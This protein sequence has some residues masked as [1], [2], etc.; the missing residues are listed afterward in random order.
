VRTWKLD[1]RRR[2][3]LHRVPHAASATE[4]DVC[5][6]NDATA[7]ASSCCC[8]R[9]LATMVSATAGASLSDRRME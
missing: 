1:C 8:S 4:A 9:S 5:I 3:S 2:S 6:S 7:D